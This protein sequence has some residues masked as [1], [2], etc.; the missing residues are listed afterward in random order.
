M[1]L[2]TWVFLPK[3][4]LFFLSKLKVKCNSAFYNRYINFRFETKS[5]YKIS[6][7][8][9]PSIWAFQSPFMAHSLLN[10][11]IYCCIFVILYLSG[12]L[13]NILPLF[14]HI[15]RFPKLNSDSFL[16]PS[17][18]LSFYRKQNHFFSPSKM[19]HIYLE[20]TS[21]SSSDLFFKFGVHAWIVFIEYLLHNLTTIQAILPYILFYVAFNVPDDYKS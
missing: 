1:T 2:S 13:T 21:I 16:I 7:I 6:S 15:P 10:E 11:F 20:N 18:T 12:I 3:I 9:C 14:F 5:N 4:L 8:L 17:F 19:L